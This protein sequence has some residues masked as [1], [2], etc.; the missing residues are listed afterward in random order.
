[1]M[2]IFTMIVAHVMMA[3]AFSYLYAFIFMH[4]D[5]KNPPGVLV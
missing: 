3:M 4:D 5:E 1:M 2:M